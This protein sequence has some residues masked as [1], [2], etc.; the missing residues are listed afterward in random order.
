MSKTEQERMLQSCIADLT[1][2]EE[3]YKKMEENLPCPPMSDEML[4]KMNKAMGFAGEKGQPFAKKDR[5]YR[6]YCGHPKCKKMPRMM[7]VEKGFQCWSCHH[8]WDLT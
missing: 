2:N 3:L 8:V 6:P 7:R 4:A 1:V 5:T